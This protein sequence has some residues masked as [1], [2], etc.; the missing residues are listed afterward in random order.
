MDAE[1]LIA[2]ARAWA[3]ADPDAGT[4][5]A[6]TALIEAGDGGALA[7]AMGETLTFGTAGIRGEVGPGSGRMN[8]AVVI[9][10][11]AG[12]AAYLTRVRP[13]G[14]SVA[15]G[16]D[17]RL[18]SRAFAGDAIGVLVAAGIPVRYFAEP[19]PTPLVAYAARRIGATA[20]VVITASHNPPQD[21]GY[22]VY[23][24]NAAQII[25]PV[26]SE[27]AREIE[28][29]PPANQVPRAEAVFEGG[30]PDARPFGPEM[31][32]DY[33][34]D[35]IAI[36]P[37]V[38]RGGPLRIVYTPLHG[39]GRD[40]AVRALW[41]AGF[42]DVLPVPEQAEPDGTFPTVAFPNPEEKGALDLAKALATAQDA[43]LILANDPDADRLAVCVPVDGG[44]RTLTGNQIGLLLA[45]FVLG[46]EHSSDTP[47]VANSIV[48]SPML[49]SIA[50]EYGA[51]WEQT[52][53]GFKWICNAAL[54]L[55]ADGSGRFAFGYEEALGYSVGR[56]V[57]DKDGIGAAVWFADL[58]MACRDAGKT[59]LDRLA[60]L[61][62]RHGL[63]VSTQKALVR[64]GAGGL[65][66]IA[67]AMASLRGPPPASLGG[68]AVEGT[69][70]YRD[71]SEVRPRWLGAQAL[72]VFHLEGGGRVLARPSGTEPKLKIYV[73]L[74]RPLEHGDDVG[75]V[76]AA[77]LE[78]ARAAAEDLA[79]FLGLA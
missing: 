58:A 47:I 2:A 8:R 46:F 72:V 22:K 45:D 54:D 30:H 53:T 36:R 39:V 55:E 28:A 5:A 44:W 63:W 59:V 24:K 23:D 37:S 41:N 13:D 4:S 51:L 29:A 70:D 20:A 43:D 75:A 79:D 65:A 26:D 34:S 38:A 25:P 40:L 62:R 3:A 1:R 74:K 71:G 18:S 17:G 66:E 78:Q 52:L 15:L 35:L 57:R 48:S 42:R 21:N 61:Y 14:G 31:A 50:V 69:T 12:L 56:V 49:G 73:D 9:R 32:D 27:I 68:L 67:A 11:T 33:V 7:A 60:A 19:A 76:E 77:L 64:P 16:Y 10:T 6:L